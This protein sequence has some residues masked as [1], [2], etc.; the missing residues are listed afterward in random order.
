MEVKKFIERL[1]QGEDED[2]TKTGA[3]I[4]R[5]FRDLER[6]VID[7]ATDFKS[8][9]WEQ[10]DTD[11]DAPYFGTWVNGAKLQ[12][13]TYAEGDWSHVQCNNAQQFN[14]EVDAMNEFYGA[15]FICKTIDND[16]AMTVVQQDR[17]AFKIGDAPIEWKATTEERYDDML[18]AVPP[19]DFGGRSF[20]LGEPYDHNAE[21]FPRFDGF[22]FKAG[23]YETTSRPVTRAEFREALRN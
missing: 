18:G 12:T 6:Y 3:T 14:A 9:G 22:R 4:R 15:G 23:K 19:I 21:G 13:L 17:G 16:G 20:L 8:E 2:T 11:Q 10:Y 1:F 7:F 5:V